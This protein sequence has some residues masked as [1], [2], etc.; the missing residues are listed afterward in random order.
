M[1]IIAILFLTKLLLFLFQPPT[2]FFHVIWCV[3]L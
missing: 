1:V 3:Q 2:E